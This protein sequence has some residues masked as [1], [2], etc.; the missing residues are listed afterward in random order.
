LIQVN[1]VLQR[2]VEAQGLMRISDK[3]A[4]NPGQKKRVRPKRTPNP[5]RET[6]NSGS[7]SRSAAFAQ[8]FKTM[9]EVCPSVA[10]WALT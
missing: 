5:N 6:M 7:A 4:S 10:M 2:G 3:D 8:A 9:N 1:I